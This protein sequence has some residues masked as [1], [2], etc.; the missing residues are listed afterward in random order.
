MNATWPP[1]RGRSDLLR[2]KAARAL[3]GLYRLTQ[4]L[5]RHAVDSHVERYV[6]DDFLRREYG[7]PMA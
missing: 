3:K 5:S 1:P 7:Q 2:Q 4:S 6:I